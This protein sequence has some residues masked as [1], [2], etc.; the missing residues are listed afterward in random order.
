MQHISDEMNQCTDGVEEKT[1]IDVGRK[2]HRCV[3]A[4]VVVCEGRRICPL[5]DPAA[6]SEYAKLNSVVVPFAYESD[7]NCKR[8]EEY[9][10]VAVTPLP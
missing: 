1:V 10:S 7:V 5:L 2:Q 8:L 4:D 6:P 3:A 9:P